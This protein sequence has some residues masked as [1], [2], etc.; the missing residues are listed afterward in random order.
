M[1]VRQLPKSATS[2][3]TPLP[4]SLLIEFTTFC[5]APMFGLSKG[6]LIVEDMPMLLSALLMDVPGPPF[7][8]VWATISCS[9][10]ALAI[11]LLRPDAYLSMA[12]KGF[13]S[14]KRMPSSKASSSMPSSLLASS[15]A[16]PLVYWGTSITVWVI[17]SPVLGSNT[18]APFFPLIGTST[19]T[20]FRGGSTA[21]ASFT[22]AMM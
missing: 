12:S 6:V 4:T 18:L 16:L 3:I 14:N 7:V 19:G 10:F 5:L 11:A 1:F 15:F 22:R 9:S 17:T 20:A 8:A 13:S 2:V 21:S